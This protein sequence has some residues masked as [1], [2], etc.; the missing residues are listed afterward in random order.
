MQELTNKQLL[1]EMHKTDKI[2][3]DFKE[4]IK[5]VRAH[6]DLSNSADFNLLV[7]EIKDLEI[8]RDEN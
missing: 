2:V 4:A 1:K 8:G 5:K 3:S 6:K 7:A